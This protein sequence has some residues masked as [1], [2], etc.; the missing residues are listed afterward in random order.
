[1]NPPIPIIGSAD[2]TGEWLQLPK[3][4]TQNKL[5]K[6][7]TQNKLKKNTK[8]KH[9]HG[10]DVEPGWIWPLAL[11]TL[12]GFTEYIGSADDAEEN[13]NKNQNTQF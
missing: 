5:K 3:H 2:D 11:I 9:F 8:H 4:K 1:M 12:I 7:K 6:H 10:K 13:I